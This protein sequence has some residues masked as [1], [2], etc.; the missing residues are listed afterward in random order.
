MSSAPAFNIPGYEMIREAGRGRH[1]DRL[2]R[3]PAF[4]RPQGR[5]QGHAPPTWNR[6][7]REVRAALPARR[8]HHGEVAAPQHRRGLRHRQERC[9][10]LHFDGVSWK[11][12]RCSDRMRRACPWAKPSAWW[13]RP[14]AACSL[15]MTTACASRPQARQ[16]HVPRRRTPVLTDFGIAR[17]KTRHPPDPDRHDGR[18]ADLHESG[19]DQRA[20]TWTGAPT[21]TAWA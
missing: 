19:A 11:A 2:S 15:R 14:P 12:A 17:A 13:C 20:T 21:S 9:R 4:A 3:D 1:G 5:D 6:R 18:H 8:P 16:H 10:H 7:R